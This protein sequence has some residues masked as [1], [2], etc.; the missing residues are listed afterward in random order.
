MQ[1]FLQ[2]IS[3]GENLFRL[4]KQKGYSQEELTVKLH[5]HGSTMSQNTYSKIERGERNIKISDFI[6][7]KIIYD[8]DY[9]EF[10]KG[11]EPPADS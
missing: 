1:W 5:L 4:R 3:I 8:V 6:A 9:S 10:F 2:N 11:L 7:L